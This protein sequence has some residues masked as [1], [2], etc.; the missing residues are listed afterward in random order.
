QQIAADGDL[1]PGLQRR[2]AL[3]LV[4]ADPR[5]VGRAAILNQECARGIA[6]DHAVTRGHAVLLEHDIV[7]RRP[8]DRQLCTLEGHGPAAA[9]G[10]VDPDADAVHGTTGCESPLLIRARTRGRRSWW[11][12]PWRSSRS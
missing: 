9:V 12:W 1:D 2:R 11:S 6:A 5:A 8:P 7:V 4:I 3:G 10:G